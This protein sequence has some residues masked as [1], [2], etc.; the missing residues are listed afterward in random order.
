M[1]SFEMGKE[2]EDMEGVFGHVALF[3]THVCC[4][5]VKVVF[6][7]INSQDTVFDINKETDPLCASPP[8]HVEAMQFLA[9]LPFQYLKWFCLSFPLPLVS[10]G[11]VMWSSPFSLTCWSLSI[12]HNS[13]FCFSIVCMFYLPQS[14]RWQ[15]WKLSPSIEPVIIIIIIISSLPFS[16]A[17]FSGPWLPV[18]ILREFQA[19]A[20][21]N[22]T[23]SQ[24]HFCWKLSS[25]WRPLHP[26]ST[27]VTSLL[28]TDPIACPTPYAHIYS[29]H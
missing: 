13:S 11:P 19:P 10:G 23:H 22:W 20:V 26:S 1:L 2:N 6:S 27:S 21:S 3:M 18:D 28:V 16:Q 24:G 7:Q 4:I 14:S 25:N 29:V 17:P 9:Q 8:L 12:F 5:Y 15:A